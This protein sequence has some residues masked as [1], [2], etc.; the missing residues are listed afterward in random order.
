[1]KIR[2]CRAWNMLAFFKGLP[3]LDPKNGVAIQEM[4]DSPKSFDQRLE[5]CQTCPLLGILPVYF[6]AKSHFYIKN[7]TQ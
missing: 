6:K 3:P 2:G 4:A 5:I 7:R 1:M